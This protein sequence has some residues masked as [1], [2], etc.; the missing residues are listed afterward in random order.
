M[1]VPK[2]TITTSVLK[3]IGLVEAAKEVI[4]NAPLVPAWEAKFRG[5]ARLKAAHYGTALEG[6]DLTFNEAKAVMEGRESEVVARERDVQEVIN[7]R[8][9]LDFIEGLKDVNNY[10]KDLLLQMHGLV[11]EKLV[12]REQTGQY[13]SSQVVL[14][15]SV[16]G[17][18]GFRPPQAAEVPFLVDELLR[19][20]NGEYGKKE[21]PVLRAGVT[22]YVLA[23]VHPFIEGN[24][25]TARALATLVL[26]N[27]GY[28]I[29]RFFALEE[30]FDKH[31]E[32]Y[33]GS[34]MTVSNQSPMLE[35][36]DLTPW[37]EVFT[38]ALAM[39]L[40]RIKEQVRELSV[41]IKIKEQ[42]GMQVSLSERQM[43][44]MEYLH[45]NGEMS[46][47]E[48]KGVLAMVSEDTILRDLKD[49][50]DKQVIDKRGSTKSA[51]YVLK[52]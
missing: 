7:Y 51:R 1:Y 29:K 43:K 5:E 52:K 2:Y 24:G 40:T 4:E 49:L 3:N 6:N 38:Q 31:A 22:H 28:D 21:H 26:F 17:E 11:V 44:L 18:I 30:Y 34:L 37:L 13:R 20:L 9:V 50:M 19:W 15:N 16:T 25:R 46:M 27:E 23:A 42:R 36:R 35:D 39:E 32:E 8:S 48:A 47:R 12:A 10:T 41:D 14:K 33:F 45:S